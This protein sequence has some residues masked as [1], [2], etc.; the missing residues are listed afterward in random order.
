MVARATA[1]PAA[2]VSIRLRDE[3]TC[4]RLEYS[5]DAVAKGEARP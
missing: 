4:A 1:V 2:K 5:V 3:A